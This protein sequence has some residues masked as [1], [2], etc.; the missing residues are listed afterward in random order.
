MSVALTSDP[1][2]SADRTSLDITFPDVL[3]AHGHATIG[4]GVLGCFLFSLMRYGPLMLSTF[5]KHV[6][7]ETSL[8][9][10]VKRPGRRTENASDAAQPKSAATDIQVY[11][12]LLRAAATVTYTQKLHHTD[13]ISLSFAFAPDALLSISKS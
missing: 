13:S 9:M 6:H 8:C 2:T 10:F 11:S 3:L 12:H 1:L 7:F 4:A 5:V